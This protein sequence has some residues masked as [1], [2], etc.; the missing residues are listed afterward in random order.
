MGLERSVQ[1]MGGI[2]PPAHLHPR[3][4]RIQTASLAGCWSTETDAVGT[5][6]AD[7]PCCGVIAVI[8]GT[9]VLII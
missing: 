1:V 9:G 3:Q 8:V 2:T 5:G 4:A 7:A 6:A